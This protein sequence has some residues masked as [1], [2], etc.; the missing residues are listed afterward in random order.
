EQAEA[1]RPYGLAMGAVLLVGGVLA[2]W[3]GR[4]RGVLAGL[5]TVVVTIV[6]F[7][8]GLLLAAPG[9][10]RPSTRDL[11]VV[12]RE[13]IKPADAVFHYWG[14]FHDFVYYSGRA[15]GL[16][17][18]LDELEVQFLPP[19]ELAT[20]FIKEDELRRQWAGPGRVWVLV[21]KRDQQDPQSVFAD[22]AFRYH[23][24]AETPAFSLV[25]NQP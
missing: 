11:A 8:V 20:R 21:R 25:S 19:A 10:N 22:P 12:A 7:Y 18:H 4:R 2:P 24:I 5:G 1:V 9:I 13:K 14:F 16:V 3:F 17:N 6:A 15:V 23:L